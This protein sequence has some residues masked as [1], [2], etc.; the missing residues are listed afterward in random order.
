MR[1]KGLWLSVLATAMIAGNASAAIINN[2]GLWNDW[3]PVIPSTSSEW[4]SVT[5][6]NGIQWLVDDPTTDANG[7]GVG[8][9]PYD[10]EQIMWY[11]QGGSLHIGMITGFNPNGE[12]SGGALASAVDYIFQAGDLFIDFGNNGAGSYDMAV[13][14]SQNG[15]RYSN[16]TSTTLYADDRF[17]DVWEAGPYSSALNTQPAS[18]PQHSIANPYRA[19]GAPSAVPF[20]TTTVHA[21]QYGTNRWFYEISIAGIDPSNF[22]TGIGLHWTME[23]GNDY[24]QVNDSDVINLTPVVPVPAAAPLGLLGMGLLALVRRVRRRTEC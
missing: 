18:Y 10:A 2:D 7:P 14:L 22:S 16:I 19:S 12:T 1:R 8:G 6:F 3:L 13:G 24:F 9:Q 23:C 15:G 17:G 5:P 4:N 11:G 21:S 20:Y